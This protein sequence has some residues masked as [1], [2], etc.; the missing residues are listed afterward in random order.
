MKTAGKFN[1][2]NHSIELNITSKTE[3]EK[4]EDDPQISKNSYQFTQVEN[5]LKIDQNK[6]VDL[7]VVVDSV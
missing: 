5:L 6:T 1:N 7:I 3:I 2:T 4:M